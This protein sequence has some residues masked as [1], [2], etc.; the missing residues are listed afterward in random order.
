M[1]TKQMSAYGVMWI[2]YNINAINLLHVSANF[3]GH[4]QAGI[5][6]RLY[7]KNIKINLQI[8]DVTFLICGIE[9]IKM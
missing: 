6:R 4:F 9:N 3:C 7:Y 1:R 8:L 2:Y 5:V